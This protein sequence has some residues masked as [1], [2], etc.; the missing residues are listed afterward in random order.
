MQPLLSV[1]IPIYNCESYLEKCLESIINQTFEDMEIILID[2]G[3][4]DNSYEIMK[5]SSEKDKRIIVVSRENSGPAATRNYGISIAKG[6]YIGFVDGD[7]YIESNMYKNLINIATEKKAEIA[8]CNYKDIYINENTENIVCHGLEEKILYDKNGVESDVIKKLTGMDNYGFFTMCN[9]IYLRDWLIKTNIKID[10]SREHG[11]DWWFNMNLYMKLNKFV[12]I[13]YVGYNYMHR[14]NN[15]LMNKYR[16][17]QFQLFL[18]GRLKV[19]SLIPENLIDFDS[20]NKNFVYEFSSYIIRTYKEVKDKRKR[21][22]LINTVITNL[23]VIE[24][25]NNVKKLPIHFKIT[26][27]LIKHRIN[28]IAKYGY[29]VLSKMV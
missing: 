27:T 15:S 13:D 20:L 10:E 22:E 26:T 6:K 9:K 24:C 4:T 19:L 18:D 14:D 23:E 12:C 17:E 7:D 25:C 29:K 16:E 11:E 8:M 28:I 21:N 3:S 2:D 5:K 1:I